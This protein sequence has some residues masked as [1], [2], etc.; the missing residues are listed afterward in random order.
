[1]TIVC[2]TDFSEASREAVRAAAVLAKKRGNRLHLVHAVNVGGEAVFDE[3]R[4]WLTAWASKQLEQGRHEVSDAASD[5]TLHLRAGSPHEALLAVAHDTHAS[6]IVVGA[7]GSGEGQARERDDGTRSTPSLGAEA[8][9][10]AA[11]S[12]VPV[13]VVR[14]AEAFG[15]WA[16]SADPL[17][18]VLGVD[19]PGHNAATLAA[20]SSLLESGG[21][22]DLTALRLYWPPSEFARLGLGG[23]RSYLEP[24][25]AVTETIAREIEQDL[26][27]AGVTTAAT[28]RAEPHMGRIA[29]RLVRFAEDESA[30]L[31]VIGSH[32]RGLLGRLWEG[33]VSRG[34]VQSAKCAALCVPAA[35]HEERPVTAFRSVLAATDFSPLGD[36]AVRLAYAAV[37]AGG[38]VH[39]VHVARGAHDSVTPRDVL[40]PEQSGV[41]EITLAELRFRLD[42]RVSPDTRVQSE[43][44]VLESDSAA[45]AIVQ[46]AERLGVD[47]ICVGTHGQ[48]A[49]L[50]ALLG[51]TATEVLKHA[52]RPVLLG[53]LT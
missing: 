3:A 34:V 1:M 35:A 12:K 21:T 26:R 38:T 17:K 24:A 7:R 41:D 39:V 20:V 27:R 47:L 31:L 28:I 4:S 49:A 15:R 45:K 42:G 22:L 33:S 16:R 2:G 32:E 19:A 13:L 6:L 30:E 9:R 44:H 46:A 23:V 37:A 40:H 52:T 50:T 8:D 48:G 36:E 43:T 25:E 18:V 51:S 29:T 10:I 14:S 5:I 11:Q 53:R